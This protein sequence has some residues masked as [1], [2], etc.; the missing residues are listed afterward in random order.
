MAGFP[1]C[2]I[3]FKIHFHLLKKILSLFHLQA[4]REAGHLATLV[5][6]CYMTC[7]P[8]VPCI[9]SF[10][11]STERVISPTRAGPVAAVSKHD[12]CPLNA[13]AP[14]TVRGW[15]QGVGKKGTKHRFF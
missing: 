10:I 14:D 12:R 8:F 11:Y 15:L 5:D 6:L 13:A 1:K 9:K 2:F 7:W 3:G 4:S